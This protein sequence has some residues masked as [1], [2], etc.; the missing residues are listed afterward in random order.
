[1]RAAF[2]ACSFDTTALTKDN[3]NFVDTGA[4]SVLPF[5]MPFVEFDP[6]LKAHLNPKSDQSF[7]ATTTALGTESY[8][9]VLH[10]QLMQ[11]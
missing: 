4:G 8:R 5:D 9:A 10:Y 7:K 1:M 6:S 3:I 11:E 2:F